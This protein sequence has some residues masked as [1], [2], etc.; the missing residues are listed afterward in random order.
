M[1]RHK[2]KREK[3]ETSGSYSR[4]QEEHDLAYYIHDRVEL[5]HQVFSVLKLKDLKAMTPAC[6]KHLSVDNIK[7][8]CTEELLGIS[9]KR[10]CAILD[11]AD[12][13][14]DTESSPSE[15]PERLETI[16]LDSISSD[17]EI[18]SQASKKSKKKHRHRD[19]DKD[20]SKKKSK[21]T[22][23]DGEKSKASRAGLTV[24]ELL[25]LQARARA[26]RA[27]L[28]QEQA[29]RK[30]TEAAE[31][32]QGASSDDDEVLV[33]EEPP[34][35]LVISSDDEKPSIAELET[36]KQNTSA[37]TEKTDDSQKV[38]KRVNNLVITVPQSKPTRK[39]KLN[40][41]KTNPAPAA[42]KDTTSFPIETVDTTENNKNDDKTNNVATI[43]SK[44]AE[45][46]AKMKEKLKKK[47]KKKGKKKTVD[48]D[49]SDHDEIMLQ[50]SDSEKLDLLE[51]LDHK[52]FDRVSS[53]SSEDSESS[54]SSESDD[55]DEN[56]QESD[57]VLKTKV[58]VNKDK[59]KVIEGQIVDKL[60]SVQ[61]NK[62]K[63]YAQENKTTEADDKSD[64]V[65]ID[66]KT[67]QKVDNSG[68]SISSKDE[69]VSE[70]NCDKVVHDNEENERSETIS[71]VEDTPNNKS[72]EK[73]DNE[74]AEKIQSVENFTVNVLES[75]DV[76]NISSLAENDQD[77]IKQVQS[78]GDC[79]ISKVP[80]AENN[81][82]FT[83][84][85]LISETSKEGTSEIN[86][87]EK[88]NV[89][90]EISEGELSDRDSSEVE[91]TEL[92]PEVVCISDD[93]GKNKSKKKHKKKEKK[94][95]KGKKSKK[96]KSDF[97]KGSDQ[98]FYKDI[99]SLNNAEGSISTDHN[100]PEPI[101]IDE[102]DIYEILEL[103]D[104][105]S[106]YEVEGT[107]LSKEPTAEEIEALSAKI[108]EIERIE[109]IT[110]E[111]IREHEL[112]L[113]ENSKTVDNN[114]TDENA[115][116]IEKISWKDR[117]L[118]SSKVKKVLT[119][120]NILNA[121]RKKNKELKKKLEESKTKELE[122]ESEK[123]ET[124]E[125]PIESNL[126]EGS[127]KQYNALQG[128]TK[129][130][131]PVKEPEMNTEENQ[132]DN[133]DAKDKE[134]AVTKEMKKDAKQLLKMYKRLLKYNDMN[135][136]KD[137]NKKKKKKQKKKNKDESVASVVN[138]DIL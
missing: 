85:D 71:I 27:Q 137:P 38:T 9:S 79:E 138:N 21:S 83:G 13:P 16:S 73:E 55:E 5:M 104:D 8:L 109:V 124:P 37:E 63:D 62:K 130:V 59:K 82:T 46:N 119:T 51:D 74:K 24:L 72:D 47:L 10:L 87:Q 132:H 113:A 81:E 15:S 123:I 64:D 101:V 66:D 40:R 33:K 120:S 117:Y 57:E 80:N 136:Q 126:E 18:L 70:A 112:S 3:P 67:F 36:E 44:A 129:Y 30:S 23:D 108:D 131:D 89:D 86:S 11:G 102:G 69:E 6:I 133:E 76:E 17:E 49:G 135:K 32:S 125:E 53:Q 98:N 68:D 25:E 58:Y 29:A 105:S 60:D 48:K 14:T 54:S 52:N 91:A 122:V 100:V 2:I 92:Q 93:E 61:E 12:P 1:S 56:S 110:D 42:D 114:K 118:G 50:L 107:V 116:D 78:S 103:S 39:I 35:V 65:N 121:L 41:T 94:S 19:R 95:K 31:S 22:E 75:R 45:N 127:I 43:A 34:E 20:R 111:E 99:E 28:Q 97:H 134:G 106:C 77:T 7:E 26:I 128:S 96:E 90:K 88:H 84:T 115:D 4:E